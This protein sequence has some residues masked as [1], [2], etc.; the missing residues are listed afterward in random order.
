[1]RILKLSAM[2]AL[3]AVAAV[4]CSSDSGTTTDGTAAPAAGSP[5]AV[6]ET[7]PAGEVTLPPVETLAPASPAA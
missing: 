1:M 5:G 2:I 3:L 4:A 6:L 7:P